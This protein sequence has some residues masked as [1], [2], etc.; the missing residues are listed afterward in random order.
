VKA[1]KVKEKSV[2][3]KEKSD[4]KRHKGIGEGTK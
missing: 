3:E 4:R 1:V 2:K